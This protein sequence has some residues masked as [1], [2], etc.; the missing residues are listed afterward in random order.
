M[1][2]NVLVN[3]SVNSNR[4]HLELAARAIGVFANDGKLDHYEL[5]MLLDFACRDQV[6]TDDEVRVLRSIFDKLGSFEL[7]MATLSRIKEV[8]RKYQVSLL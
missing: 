5:D 1:N 6:L 2:N 3:E 4:D 7:D 8:E